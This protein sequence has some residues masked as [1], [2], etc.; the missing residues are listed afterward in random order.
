MVAG[1]C[2]AGVLLA[3][4]Q[5]AVVVPAKQGAVTQR[6]AEA[7]DDATLNGHDRL[8]VDAGAT[9]AVTLYTTENRG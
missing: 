9:P 3:T 7:I 5:T 4:V 6:G 8:Q 2:A 1:Q